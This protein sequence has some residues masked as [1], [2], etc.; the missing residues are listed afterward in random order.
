MISGTYTMDYNLFTDAAHLTIWGDG[1]PGTI[2][3]A[4]IA[5]NN[6]N[7]IHTVYGRIPGNQN[8]FAGAY[9]DTITVTITY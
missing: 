7:V 2:L 6:T 1:T 3:V 9:T 4:G 5:P 8:L